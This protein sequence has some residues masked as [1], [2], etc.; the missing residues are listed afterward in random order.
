VP[1]TKVYPGYAHIEGLDDV[2]QHW[3]DRIAYFFEHYK[4]LESGKWVKA[5]RLGRRRRSQADPG[6]LDHALQHVRRKAE[7]LIRR[8]RARQAGLFSLDAGRSSNPIRRDTT[9]AMYPTPAI[10]LEH[11]EHAGREPTGRMS[12]SR[13]PTGC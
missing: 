4:D 8:I 13:W 9:V 1:V 10:L 2:P 11:G 12:P 5:R 7:F 6:R 3:R